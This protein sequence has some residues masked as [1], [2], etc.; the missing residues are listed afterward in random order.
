MGTRYRL[1]PSNRRPP[2]AGQQLWGITVNDALAPSDDVV[3]ETPEEIVTVPDQG[4]VLGEIAEP[5]V[6]PC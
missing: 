4:A 1:C 2:V 6:T 3:G 5:E